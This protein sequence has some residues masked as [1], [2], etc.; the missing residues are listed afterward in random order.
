MLNFNTYF[1]CAF[2]FQGYDEN[3]LSVDPAS[4][5]QR[6]KDSPEQIIKIDH[7]YA[8]TLPDEESFLCHKVEAAKKEDDI[9]KTIDE[10]EDSK[11]FPL[12]VKEE[13]CS[14][15]PSTST[16][17]GKR[18]RKS[19]AD[20]DFIYDDEAP[21]DQSSD[22]SPSSKK[23]MKS[24]KKKSGDSRQSKRSRTSSVSDSGSVTSGPDRYRELRDRNNEASRRSR[25]NRKQR[26]VEMMERST[27][28]EKENLQ[29]KV[30]AENLEKRV[31]T[32]REILLKVVLAKNKSNN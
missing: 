26:E 30:K 28:L 12:A 18:V 7:D 8:E 4:I 16:S 17:V 29:L 2:L 6:P 27:S 23:R 3:L 25:M 19:L 1:F 15:S 10:E 14:P 31:K 21:S 32:L 20:E 5:S 22:W 11:P 24:C 13:P 9:L